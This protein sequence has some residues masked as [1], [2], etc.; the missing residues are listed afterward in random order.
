M[1]LEKF[2]TYREILTYFYRQFSLTDIIKISSQS[3]KNCSSSTASRVKKC[4]FEKNAFKVCLSAY[5]DAKGC[6]LTENKIF[7]ST[8]PCIYFIFENLEYIFKEMI[9]SKFCIGV[10]P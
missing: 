1:Q 4:S 5:H 9:F 6:N 2:S 7:L 10:T 3:D 8:R